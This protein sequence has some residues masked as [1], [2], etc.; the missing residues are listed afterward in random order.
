M[1]INSIANN[2]AT[3]SSG[4]AVSNTTIAENFDAFLALLTTQL[5][6]QNPLDPLDTNQFTQQ[7][8]QFAGVE[9]QMKTNTTLS[10][11]LAINDATQ[12]SN[13]ANFIGKSVVAEGS[14]SLLSENNAAWHVHVAQDAPNTTIVVKD[15]EGNQV[16]SRDIALKSGSQAFVWNGVTS[17]GSV[18]ADG[19]YT[20]TVSARD[21]A[22]AAVTASTDFQGTVDGVK[23]Q[24]GE[25]VLNIGAL[26]VKLSSVKTIVAP[27][28]GGGETPEE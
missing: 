10:A 14:T 12:L 20:I 4:T 21:A 19:F 16:Y 2:A 27:S 15:A 23:L 17:S 13:A 1:A 18:A 9:Q 11:L 26:S 6:N 8:V 25:P 7:L 28:T 3:Q 5:R 22:G 24:N